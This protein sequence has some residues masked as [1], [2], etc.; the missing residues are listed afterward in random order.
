MKK[1][2][3]PGHIERDSKGSVKSMVALLPSNKRQFLSQDAKLMLSSSTTNASSKLDVL[4]A[5]GSLPFSSGSRL[6]LASLF[7]S[8]DAINRRAVAMTSRWLDLTSYII[9]DAA[10][11]SAMLYIDAQ[12]KTVKS[13]LNEQ[14]DTLPTITGLTQIGV[15]FLMSAENRSLID[16]PTDKPYSMIDVIRD[17]SVLFRKAGDEPE[18]RK[19]ISHFV[20]AQSSV[21]QKNSSQVSGNGQS[22]HS[23]I[24]ASLSTMIRMDNISASF[25]TLHSVCSDDEGVLIISFDDS[26]YNYILDLFTATV[27]LLLRDRW[28]G[29][30]VLSES[31]TSYT[32]S[33]ALNK[34]MKFLTDSTGDK[35]PELSKLATAFSKSLSDSAIDKKLLA[36]MLRS[37]SRIIRNYNNSV[38]QLGAYIGS[39]RKFI[40]ESFETGSDMIES[41]RDMISALSEAGGNQELA[42]S[43]VRNYMQNYLHEK[44]ATHMVGVLATLAASPELVIADDVLSRLS[45]AELASTYKNST[46]ASEF[47]SLN[48]AANDRLPTAFTAGGAEFLIQGNSNVSIDL[49]DSGIISK[50][51]GKDFRALKN[52]VSS[53]A[54]IGS[55][56]SIKVEIKKIYGMLL[57][58]AAGN[59]AVRV[60]MVSGLQKLDLSKP[61]SFSEVTRGASLVQVRQ[62]EAAVVYDSAARRLAVELWIIKML[63]SL[64]DV[65]K[66]Y[67]M[68]GKSV[69]HA[70]IA[71]TLSDKANERAAVIMQTIV[72]IAN[73]FFP[74]A[75]SIFSRTEDS[76]VIPEVTINGSSHPQDCYYALVDM[77]SNKPSYF[78]LIDTLTTFRRTFETMNASTK[79]LSM[80][81]DVYAL[82][83]KYFTPF[84]S[85]FLGGF[86]FSVDKPSLQW[87][88]VIETMSSS[89]G[90]QEALWRNSDSASFS[91]AINV[92]SNTIG[93]FT[94]FAK[95][96]N[97]IKEYVLSDLFNSS[98]QTLSFKNN[99]CKEIIR[100][101]IDNKV[102][103]YFKSDSDA[104][105][106]YSAF[107]TKYGNTIMSLLEFAP[108]YVEGNVDRHFNEAIDLFVTKTTDVLEL[109]LNQVGLSKYTILTPA[110]AMHMQHYVSWA[111]GLS[112]TYFPLVLRTNV[113]GPNGLP[114]GDIKIEDVVTVSSR[115]LELRSRG[116]RIYFYRRTADCVMSLF[117]YNVKYV[118]F[119]STKLTVVSP[120]SSLFL[121]DDDSAF[122]LVV[123]GSFDIPYYDTVRMGHVYAVVLSIA[124]QLDA[125]FSFID[126]KQVTSQDSSLKEDDEE[127]VE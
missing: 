28:A 124:E 105:L 87:D 115:I 31:T 91:F 85:H 37:I 11:L 80:T 10:D 30:M 56:D 29:S 9:S 118:D 16:T 111:S 13:A 59:E 26:S 58:N 67:D 45:A 120:D 107:S 62:I 64:F 84:Y 41:F 104:H 57:Q 44:N 97:H 17:V 98:T 24:R 43:L 35:I 39:S 88:K 15:E 79:T 89:D 112:N 123:E 82:D 34:F 95:P 4:M 126:E 14:S 72:D 113:D 60:A 81:T 73:E 47:L 96:K 90:L 69:R 86:D 101:V 36:G 54:T 46:V 103:R 100:Q 48:H 127:E 92:D 42:E 18:V 2:I 66:F 21:T 94:N 83:R 33:E 99:Y 52:I 65:I 102:S 53:A 5:S 51:G 74:Y 108:D 49:N 106:R 78:S 55:N 119:D 32:H 1:I 121:I 110:E 116:N 77:L 117:D 125:F 114:E 76:T 68:Y 122:K 25:E 6:H 8:S 70:L 20:A 22:L 27:I 50:I 40:D 19:L 3:V 61:Y 63:A 75:A 93:E 109:V 71:D 23:L 38:R 12:G 7:K